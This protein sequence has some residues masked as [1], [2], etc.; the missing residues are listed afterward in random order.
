MSTTSIP[1]S[2]NSLNLLN[3]LNSYE[4]GEAI[5]REVHAIAV[6]GTQRS[7]SPIA[8]PEA[9]Q[10]WS[11]D[12][13]RGRLT[14]LGGFFRFV[15]LLAA[16]DLEF[17]RK[18]VLTLLDLAREYV[19]MVLPERKPVLALRPQSEDR[20]ENRTDVLDIRRAR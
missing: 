12:L 16:R 15:D 5:K 20:T 14:V 17:G 10:H 8:V 7:A 9:W 1:E 11:I 18:L 13:R 4:R 19:D 2:A 3:S 6:A